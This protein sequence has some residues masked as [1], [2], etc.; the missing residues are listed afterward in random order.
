LEQEANSYY[1]GG[2]T[3]PNAGG[4]AYSQNKYLADPLKRIQTV[5]EPGFDFS[6]DKTNGINATKTWFFA[7]TN[8]TCLS[9]PTDAGLDAKSDDATKNYRLIVTRD[10]NGKYFQ[11]IKDLFNR[12]IK[13]CSDPSSSSTGDE[14]VTEYEYDH[15]GNPTKIKYPGTGGAVDPAMSATYQY[16]ATGQKTSE[17]LPDEGTVDMVYDRSG[18]LRF[19][20]DEKQ[21]VP[22]DLMAFNYTKYDAYGR[23]VEMGTVTVPEGDF[24]YYFSESFADQ[25]DFPTMTGMITEPHIRYY[26]DTQEG[27]GTFLGVDDGFI[28][29]SNLK[30]RLVG[31]VASNQSLLENGEKV[32]DSYSYDA[33]GRVSQLWKVIPGIPT[34]R[35]TFTYDLQGRL[36]A[37]EHTKGAIGSQST[38][39]KWAYEYDQLGRPIAI[40]WMLPNGAFQTMVSYYYSA[41]GEMIVKDFYKNGSYAGGADYMYNIRG[42]LQHIDGFSPSDLIY[43]QENSFNQ[44]TGTSAP[45]FNGNISN[46]YFT[47]QLSPTVKKEYNPMYYYD[48]ANRL[49]AAYDSKGPSYEYE[50]FQYDSKSRLTFKKEDGQI[51]G[52]YVY[53]SGTNR[54]TSVSGHPTRAASGTFV[55]D[56]NGNMVLDRSKKMAI[57]YDWRG[58]PVLFRF[59]PSLPASVSWDQALNLGNARA[60]VEMIYDASG[61]RVLK[62]TVRY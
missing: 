5:G 46:S 57:K 28:F 43:S 34:Q 13:K 11:S 62:R 16:T 49:V 17:R 48:G 10:P 44:P 47:Y 12:D 6:L 26:Y 2:W 30:G 3:T 41:T 1:S 38:T 59:Y 15:V 39:S 36:L 42:W 58:L 31:Q 45:Q 9:N 29:G 37:K 32:L 27:A 52:P 8:A 53:A 61:S 35:F 54:V 50:G 33:E 60:D 40:K 20:R 22:A 23:P 51:V 25:R 18:R 19:T 24:N 7:V 56:P 21:R 14:I 4:K 55:Y